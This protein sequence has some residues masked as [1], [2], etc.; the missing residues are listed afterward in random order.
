[1]LIATMQST[2]IL[3]EKQ[4]QHLKPIPAGIVHIRALSIRVELQPPHQVIKDNPRSE[5][6]RNVN[7]CVL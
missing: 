4:K 3:L 6:T 1:M 2:H 5:M 7:K